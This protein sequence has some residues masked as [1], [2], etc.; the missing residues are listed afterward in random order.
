MTQ[1]TG[2]STDP[3]KFYDEFKETFEQLNPDQLFQ[4]AQEMVRKMSKTLYLDIKGTDTHGRLIRFVKL[5]PIVEIQTLIQNN[6]LEKL[7]KSAPKEYEKIR[8]DVLDR[9]LKE[10]DTKQAVLETQYNNGK[11][12]AFATDKMCKMLNDNK[13]VLAS[14]QNK[15]NI[16]SYD[17]VIK[18]EED[19]FKKL[20]SIARIALQVPESKKSEINAEPTEPSPIIEEPTTEH[21][22]EE[23][24]KKEAP[25][26]K[27][28]PAAH[29]VTSEPELKIMEEEERQA[30]EEKNKEIDEATLAIRDAE[31]EALNK[32]SDAVK[33]SREE[34]MIHKEADRVN[35]E[36]AEDTER[37]LEKRAE[38]RQQIPKDAVKEQSTEVD[39]KKQE[40]RRHPQVLKSNEVKTPAPEPA[41][42]KETEPNTK[43]PEP[44]VASVKSPQPPPEAK[45]PEVP[46]IAVKSPE[47]AAVKKP[48]PSAAA[49]KSLGP[50][51]RK[52]DATV[53][54]IKNPETEAK[55]SDAP[56][57]A[58]KNPEPPAK[59][60]EPPSA[61]ANSQETNANNQ[62][63]P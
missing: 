18:C 42:E 15:E 10:L 57:A 17:A 3:G 23:A 58:V 21:P 11:T 55:K 19:N 51:S 34:K 53:A 7:K 41:P 24:P 13:I 61:K 45:K 32:L 14:N 1:A 27:A 40:E 33:E 22:K 25:K 56:P 4:N 38:D 36:G 46:A 43:N 60:P 54:A 47:P 52:L 49:I 6:E 39:E 63:V 59:M 9:I 20:I 37:A 2:S 16:K 48:D 44:A 35:A 29:N 31:K 62:E 8:N 12:V 26:S 30:R 5:N 28:A 50:I